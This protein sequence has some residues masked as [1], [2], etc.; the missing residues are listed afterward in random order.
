[1]EEVRERLD[2]EMK[3][4]KRKEEERERQTSQRVIQ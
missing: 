4:R 1:M 3:G 2:K